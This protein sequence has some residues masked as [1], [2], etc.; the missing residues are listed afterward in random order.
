MSEFFMFLQDAYDVSEHR[1]KVLQ[2]ESF[3]ALRLE[4]NLN[5]FPLYPLIFSIFMQVLEKLAK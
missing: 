4:V 1:K 5:V 3:S 2:K